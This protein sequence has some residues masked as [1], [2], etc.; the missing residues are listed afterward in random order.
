MP[1][2]APAPTTDRDALLAAILAAPA[3]DAP[4]LVY[5]DWLDEHG[6]GD[7]AEFIRLGCFLSHN[8]KPPGCEGVSRGQ[9]C[10]DPECPWVV[11]CKKETRYRKLLAGPHHEWITPPIGWKS[12]WG[13][14]VGSKTLEIGWVNLTPE[15]FGTASFTFAK[16]F[17]AG[18]RLTAAAFLG[19]PCGNCGPEPSYEGDVNPCPDCSGSGR[20]P[21]VAGALFRS[22]PVEAVRLTDREPLE[23]P[24]TNWKWYDETGRS[25]RTGVHTESNLP[26]SLWGLLGGFAETAVDWVAGAKWYPSRDAAHDALSAAACRL[27]RTLAGVG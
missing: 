1:A 10:D 26:T 18:V 23:L 9:K 19:G 12:V 3:D 2:T 16:G 21:G 22:Q 15:R 24:S 25:G 8:P 17:V 27:G 11:Y 4:R 14:P 20:T 6:E 5:A 13:T 7:R